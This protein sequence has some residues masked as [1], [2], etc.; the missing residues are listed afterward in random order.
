MTPENRTNLWKTWSFAKKLLA[1]SLV[2]RFVFAIVFLFAGHATDH[3]EL[4]RLSGVIGGAIVE[5]IV[6][7][8]IS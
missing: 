6:F 7:T 8:S 5:A 4:S 2:T 3:Y 1:A